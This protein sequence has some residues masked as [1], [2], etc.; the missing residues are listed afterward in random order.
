MRKGRQI[1]GPF[2]L[3]RWFPSWRAMLEAGIDEDA[4][5]L[6]H[7]PYNRNFEGL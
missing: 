7:G 1:A 4:L 3:K 2:V 5:R 6:N